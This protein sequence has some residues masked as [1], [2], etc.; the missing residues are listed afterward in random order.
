M[1]DDALSR[2]YVLLSALETKL[3]SFEFI[4]NLYATDHDFKEIFK[5]CSKATY[6]K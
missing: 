6:G 4:K 5:K 1:V 3:L 2:R